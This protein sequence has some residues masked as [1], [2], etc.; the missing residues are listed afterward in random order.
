M[1]IH[2][3]HRCPVHLYLVPDPSYFLALRINN[4]NLAA[5]QGENE[6]A[7]PDGHGLR[8]ADVSLGSPTP[9]QTQA[10]HVVQDQHAVTAN[11]FRPSI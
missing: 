1:R 2:L 11:I 3:F 5:L 4:E 6:V 10:A 9:S 7:R 8:A